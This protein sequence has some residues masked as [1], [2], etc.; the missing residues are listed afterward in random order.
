[1]NKDQIVFL[2]F[3]AIL[4]FAAIFITAKYIN[5]RKN[6]INKVQK[7]FL[8]LFAVIFS[9]FTYTS[10]AISVPEVT[11]VPEITKVTEVPEDKAVLAP[12]ALKKGDKICVLE[13]SRTA[14]PEAL[15]AINDKL[16]KITADLEKRGFK[17]EVYNDSFK[18]T[19]L[20]LG[21]GTEQ[22]R[23]DLFN[24]AVKDPGIKAIFS[25]RG[26]YGAMHILDKID[27]DAFRE[28]RKIFVGFSDETAIHLA[29]LEK[30]KVITFHGPMVGATIN[31]QETK[32]FDN[33]FEMLMNPKAETELCN[34]DDNTPFKA[35]KSGECEAQVFGGNACLI[36]SLIGTP[37]EPSYKKKILFFE[38][39]SENPYRIHRMLWQLKLAERLKEVSGI[40][41]GTLTP[42]PNETEESL[43]KACFDVIEDLKIP[44]IYNFHAGHI[45]NPL[46]LPLGATLKIKDNKVIVKE[47]VVQNF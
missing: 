25:F 46:T 30:A 23:A 33:L 42:A 17:V 31:Y 22:E 34:I 9:T 20:G 32:C 21:D 1:M 39:I 18:P 14:T 44:I 19:K 43:L 2:I 11:K 38:E 10:I 29:I 47:Q 3:F 37:Y 4:F 35:Y 45:K 7:I 15:K 16:P 40:I 26:G 6:L 24:K 12:N 28:N 41:I 5:I 13:P 8:A 36:Q 27:Y